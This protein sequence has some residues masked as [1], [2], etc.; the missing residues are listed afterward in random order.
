MA[1]IYKQALEIYEEIKDMDFQD[2][3]EVKEPD[4]TCIINM[5]LKVGYNQT[6]LNLL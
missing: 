2:Y 4:L 1:D 6:L 3:E 5:I